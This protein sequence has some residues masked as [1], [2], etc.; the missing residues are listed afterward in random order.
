ML[1]KYELIR[2]VEEFNTKLCFF[3][4]VYKLVTLRVISID[5]HLVVDFLTHI[6]GLCNRNPIMLTSFNKICNEKY[7]Y[8]TISVK[9]NI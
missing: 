3:F 1:F 7:F 4:I 9:I 5:L 8:L 2:N 6:G